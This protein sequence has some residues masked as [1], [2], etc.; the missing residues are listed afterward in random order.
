SILFLD[1]AGPALMIIT[2]MTVLILLQRSGELHPLLAAGIPM[3]R[4]LRPIIIACV[5]LNAVL[6]FNQEL[7]VPRVVFLEHE[8]RHQNDPSQSEVESVTDHST[9]IWIDGDQISVADK[10]IV[11]ASF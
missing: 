9:Q 8:I 10:T 4:I 6:V 5:G 11:R 3:Y 2:V 7:L 1:R